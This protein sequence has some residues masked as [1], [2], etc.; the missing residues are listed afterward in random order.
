ML[1][2]VLKVSE[3]WAL[4]GWS[5]ARIVLCLWKTFSRADAT[6]QRSE[7]LRNL[8]VTMIEEHADY[9]KKNVRVAEYRLEERVRDVHFWRFRQ[10]AFRRGCKNFKSR[11]INIW[12]GLQGLCRF[13]LMFVFY[14]RRLEKKTLLPVVA[15]LLI[16]PQGRSSQKELEKG[17]KREV[18]SCRQY[19]ASHPDPPS[20]HSVCRRSVWLGRGGNF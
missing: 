14:V 11:D 5:R 16:F 3:C 4:L 18:A 9:T 20:P 19:L 13:F 2:S 6:R 1:L 10:V 7:A 8:A 15:C 12:K 17:Q